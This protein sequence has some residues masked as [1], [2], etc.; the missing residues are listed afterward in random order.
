[1]SDSEPSPKGVDGNAGSPEIKKP[2]TIP[3]DI[4]PDSPPSP[5]EAA[6]IARVEA[7]KVSSIRAVEKIE[8]GVNITGQS[9]PGRSAS[10]EVALAIA[11]TNIPEENLEEYTA[12]VFNTARELTPTEEG[13]SSY[14]LC[15]FVSVSE[16]VESARLF[17]QFAQKWNDKFLTGTNDKRIVKNRAN[18]FTRIIYDLSSTGAIPRPEP[19][20]IQEMTGLLDALVD[21]YELAYTMPENKENQQVFNIITSGAKEIGLSSHDPDQVKKVLQLFQAVAKEPDRNLSRKFVDN[22]ATYGRHHVLTDDAVKG[23]EEKLLPAMRAEDP[24]VE[25]LQKPINSFGMKKGDF[26]AADFI[27]HAYGLRVTP[28]NINELM[29]ISREFATSDFARF[30]QNRLDGLSL[31]GPFL[32][33]RDFIH[34]QRPYVHEVISEMMNYYDTGDKNQLEAVIDKADSGYLSSEERRKLILDRELYDKDIEE[35]TNEGY[36]PN[37]KIKTIDVLRRLAENTKPVK[38]FPPVTSDPEFNV[39]LAKLTEDRSRTSLQQTLDYANSRLIEIMQ[40][41]EVGIGPNHILAF[42]WLE[43]KGFEALQGLSYEGQMEAYG[44]GWFHSILRFQELTWSP[45]NYDEGEFQ[46]FLSQVS[47]AKNPNEAYSLISQRELS[48]INKLAEKHKALGREDRVDALWSGNIAHELI[49][50]TDLRPAGTEYGRRQRAEAL[51]PERDRLSG[52]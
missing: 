50:L 2:I 45:G 27:C 10:E 33:L 37:R 11:Q 24:Q 32:A 21:T 7:R 8:G 16:S 44:Q 34:D 1:M 47:S 29:M 52:D 12:F 40:K 19:R 31:A 18:D 36:D 13:V 30:E 35:R 5:E 20:S 26:G 51:K 14:D 28:S 38:N 15:N 6:E 23:F 46:Q 39:L 17:Q 49:G 4:I 42:S 48:H 41:G 25:I 9:Y 3:V 22:I 43:R